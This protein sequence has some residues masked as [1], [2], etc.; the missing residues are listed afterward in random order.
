MDYQ[1]SVGG[2]VSFILFFILFYFHM[3]YAILCGL[4]SLVELLLLITYNF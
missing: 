1:V 4:V 3:Q 2:K